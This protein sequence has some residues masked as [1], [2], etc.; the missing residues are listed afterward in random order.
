MPIAKPHSGIRVF[1]CLLVLAALLVAPAAARAQSDEAIEKATK[2]NKKA[3]EEY[4]NLNFEEA[5]KILK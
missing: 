2:Q 3:I 1:S 4:E 5:R